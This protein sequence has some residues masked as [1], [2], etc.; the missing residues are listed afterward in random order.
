MNKTKIDWATMTWNPITGCLH[1][2]PYCYA[3]K[4]AERFQDTDTPDPDSLFLALYLVDGTVIL[5]EPV[6]SG[7]GK[8]L[9][10]VTGFTPTF[11]RYR[12]GEPAAMKK[13]QTIFVCSMA[14]L[15]GDWVPDEWIEKVFT[16]CKAA[17]QHRYLFLTK[18]PQRL[19]E[20]ANTGRLPE[21]ENFWYGSTIAG[22]KAFSFPGRLRDNTFLS[23]EPL[24]EPLHAGL[25]SFGSAQW[26]I[27]GAET[28]NRK[29]RVVPKREWIENIVDAAS[30]TRAAV[31]MKESL[32]PIWGE[33]LIQEYP[34]RTEQ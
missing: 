17:P 34:W 18:N 31:F 6:K 28:G 23:I 16:A 4:I 24:L 32:R 15:F 8:I 1:G 7:N 30:I 13:P 25:G 9:P 27:I 2:C 12:L 19:C 20:L 26:I 11:H 29:G 21:N 33:P 5:G 22:P 3:R 14:D 10:F